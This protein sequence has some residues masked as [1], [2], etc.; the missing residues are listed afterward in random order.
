MRDVPSHPEQH[1][2]CVFRV[3][4]WM[5]TTC[6]ESSPRPISTS[7]LHPSRGFHLWPINPM[8]YRGPYPRKVVGDLILE[9]ASRLDAFSGYPFRT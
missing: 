7:Q 3:A 4:Q 1:S 6:R 8:V 5:P 9:R 2:V